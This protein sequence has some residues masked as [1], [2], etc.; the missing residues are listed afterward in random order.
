MPQ[1]VLDLRPAVILEIPPVGSAA[2][3]ALMRAHDRASWQKVIRNRARV[4]FLLVL[5]LLDPTHRTEPTGNQ[6]ERPSLLRL[7]EHFERLLRLESDD[8]LRNLAELLL[9]PE[10]PLQFA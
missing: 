7:V 3:R 5:G 4:D 10:P 2:Y 1:I 8:T 9:I 6:P